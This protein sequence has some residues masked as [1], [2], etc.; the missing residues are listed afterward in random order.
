VTRFEGHR[1]DPFGHGRAAQG[2]PSGSVETSAPALT[3]SAPTP[4]R[5]PVDSAYDVDDDHRTQPMDTVRREDLLRTE[6]RSG[7]SLSPALPVPPPAY[8]SA[9]TAVRPDMRR[10]TWP[11]PGAGL[12]PP[13]LQPATLRQPPLGMSDDGE[14]AYASSSSPPPPPP[15]RSEPFAPRM[16]SDRVPRG[17]EPAARPPSYPALGQ[18]Q[19]PAAGRVAVRR[20]S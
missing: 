10:T 12:S 7:L 16:R 14:D 18:T 13:P 2:N 6:R 19:D 15:R 17:P 3:P 4:R 1:E 11:P 8:S 9:P 5:Q 20:R